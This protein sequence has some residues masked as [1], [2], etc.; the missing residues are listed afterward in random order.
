MPTKTLFRRRR[1]TFK[2]SRR[3]RSSFRRRRRA[4]FK[5]AMPSL[6]HAITI[7]FRGRY[8][9]TPDL[10]STQQHTVVVQR[11]QEDTSSGNFFAYNRSTVFAYQKKRWEQF[12][13]TGVAVKWTPSPMLKA[14]A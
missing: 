8:P 9:V 7:P 11:F 6:K 10:N 3:R 5:K 2:K 1:P 13:V 12:A 4:S 14:G